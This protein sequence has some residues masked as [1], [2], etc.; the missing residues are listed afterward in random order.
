VLDDFVRPNASHATD[1]GSARSAMSFYNR[2]SAR[3]AMLSGRAVQIG[4]AFPV[5]R[6]VGGYR[7]EARSSTIS[8]TGP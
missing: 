6:P 8:F 4:R 7:L 5:L 1:P 3:T 2:Q